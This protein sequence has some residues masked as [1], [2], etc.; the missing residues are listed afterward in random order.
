MFFRYDVVYINL[1]HK[2]DWLI[3]KNPLNKVPCIELEGGETL[4]ESLIIA[5]YLDDAYPQNKL[6]S[7]QPL[8]K[9]TE[10]LLIDRFNAVIAI[11]YKVFATFHV[12]IYILRLSNASRYL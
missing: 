12:C 3:E 1:T 5:E 6:Y 11:M 8:A 9:A 4:Y 7:S 10:K 2:P